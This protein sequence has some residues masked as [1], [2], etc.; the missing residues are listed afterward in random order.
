MTSSYTC[1]SMPSAR[2]RLHNPRGPCRPTLEP[3]PSASEVMIGLSLDGPS[4]FCA[5]ST[6]EHVWASRLGLGRAEWSDPNLLL[7][8]GVRKV[9]ELVVD[10]LGVH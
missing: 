4:M 1:V 6:K 9:D 3:P 7:D 2:S 5:A 10:A 8:G